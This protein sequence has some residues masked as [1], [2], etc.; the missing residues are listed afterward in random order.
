MDSKARQQWHIIFIGLGWAVLV[1]VIIYTVV[2]LVK[3]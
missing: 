3:S 2:V 1:S